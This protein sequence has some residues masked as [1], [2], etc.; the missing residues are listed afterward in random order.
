LSE[1]VKLHKNWIQT[2]LIDIAE[3]NPTKPLKNTI[4][5]SLLVSFLPMKCIEEL[6]GNYDLSDIRKYGEVKKG[7]TFFK[8]GD[9]IFA[10]ITPC[11]ENGK[12][13]IVNELKNGIGFGSTEF[14]VIRLVDD[15]MSRPFYFYYLIQDNFRDTA[16]RNMKGT[17]GQLRVSSDYI[18]NSIVPIPPINEQKR[19]VSKIEELFSELDNVKDTLE[20]VKLQLVQY[21]QSL[22]KSAFEGKLTEEWRIEKS[23]ELESV[24]TILKILDNDCSNSNYLQIIKKSKKLPISWEFIKI[25]RMEKFVGSGITPKGGKS[26]YQDEGIPFIRSQNVYPNG[27]HL[28]NIAYVSKEL[29]NKMSRTHIQ[30]YDVLLNITGAS[31]G[32]ANFIPSNFGEGN[33]NQHVCIIRCHSKV[34]PQFF[35]YWLN[36]PKCQDT[37]FSSQQGQTRQGLNYSQIRDM[38]FPICSLEEQEQIVSKLEQGL[39]LIEN[40]ENITNTM[41]KKLETLRSSILKQAFEG[42]L[43][44]QDP[45]DEPAEKL[46]QRI[47]EQQT[48]TKSRGKK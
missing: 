22:L 10:K 8:N 3:I 6:T 36:S 15:K 44:P 34:N 19:I 14:H 13:A 4:S 41:L 43:V 39:S 24:N 1:L 28:E 20:K 45:N 11:M 23:D 47:K 2:Q 31:I 9:I 40:T 29:H 48:K 37:I 30:D 7:Y 12:I 18:K 25:G 46:L 33:V 21:R 38:V 27:L 42:K 26:V 35:S 5:D 17:A 16:Q 32:R